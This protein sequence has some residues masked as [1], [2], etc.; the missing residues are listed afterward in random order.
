MVTKID[1]INGY[2]LGIAKR[3]G[4]ECPQLAEHYKAVKLEINDLRQT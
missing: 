1:A 4:I 2:A 3:V